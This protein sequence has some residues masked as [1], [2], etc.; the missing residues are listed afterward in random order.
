MVL[1]TDLF[2]ICKDKGQRC[3]SISSRLLHSLPAQ[4]FK[5]VLGCLLLRLHQHLK[6][7]K[8]WV[9]NAD[10]GHGNFLL[11]LVRA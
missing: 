3:Y 4:R 2:G 5:L 9:R 8:P 10:I 1:Y 6:A 11:R 7:L